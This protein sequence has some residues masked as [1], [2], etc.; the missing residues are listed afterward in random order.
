LGV[1]GEVA[2][3]AA[4]GVIDCLSEGF[5]LVTRYLWV[6]LIP[7]ALDALL[8]FAPRITAQPLVEQFLANYR[9]AIAAYGDPTALVGGADFQAVES[10]VRQIGGMNLLG[11]LGWNPA[12]AVVPSFAGPAL[13][14]G[15]SLTVGSAG[16]LLALVVGVQL[17][18]LLLGCLYLGAIGQLVRDGRPSLGRLLGRVG[19][20]WLTF[21][22]Y[23]ALLVAVLLGVTLL[24]SLALAVLSL[25]SVSIAAFLS[26]ALTTAA[27]F[28]GLYLAIY[29]FFLPAAVV[30][31]EHRPLDAIRSSMQTVRGSFWSSIGLI[32]LTLL[33]DQGMLVIWSRLVATEAPWGLLVAVVGNAF[34]ATG[35]TA[36]TMYFYRSRMSHRPVV[37]PTPNARRDDDARR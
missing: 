34:V 6:V 27:V 32:A 21:V 28:V 1:R 15:A 36:A 2:V 33:I 35:L 19:G 8:F 13:G 7:F 20:Y 12:N 25:I 9:Q 24:L 30:V 5:G 16:D 23:I 37:P 22:A 11:L 10:Q 17:V 3:K 14:A 29:L 4:P 18:G 26:A 31:G